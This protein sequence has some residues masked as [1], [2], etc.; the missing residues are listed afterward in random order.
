MRDGR[1]LARSRVAEDPPLPMTSRRPLAEA[2]VPAP[3]PSGGR[4]RF[5][6]VAKGMSIT[7]VAFGHSHLVVINPL[8]AAA[9]QSL[10]LLRMP[11]F[12]FLSGVFFRPAKPFATLLREKSDSLLKPY[13]VTL[14]LVVLA[15]V[16]VAGADPFAEIPRMLYGVG[17]SIDMPWAP[18]W[19]LAHLWLVFPYAWG[20]VRIA[21][22][23]RL[24]AWVSA[25]LLAAGALTGLSYLHLF[26][27][28]P[29]VI[30]DMHAP[31]SGL[32]FSADVLSISAAYFLL[33]F[34]L[35]ER[36]QRFR[37]NPALAVALLVIFA[38]LDA[39]TDLHLDLNQRVVEQP[40]ATAACS[41]AGIYLALSAA[42]A[43][44]ATRRLGAAF[45]FLGFN[46]LF[47]LLFHTFLETQCRHL[48]STL[49]SSRAGLGIATTAYVWSVPLAAALG[50]VIRR[51]AFLSA[52]YLPR[53]QR[54]VPGIGARTPR[55]VDLE[56]QPATDAGLKQSPD[57]LP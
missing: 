14:A 27:D 32:P 39:A 35:R 6:D 36:V 49:M 31:L 11:L 9:N 30:G 8:A 5:I 37:P 13:L 57:F 10:G 4:L 56:P 38:A 25:A 47:V 7:L 28:L 22:A 12:F 33:G 15:R 21:T 43:L 42:H 20:L 1:G 51:S 50:V 53:K 29:I 16:L 17:T 26:R 45:A 23:A 52:L 19:Y 46:S 3:A 18:L 41:L 40:I 48:L 54:R 44:S 34:A 24:P 2:S 55:L